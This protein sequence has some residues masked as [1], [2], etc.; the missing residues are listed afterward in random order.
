MENIKRI[1]NKTYVERKI[2]TTE[3]K[4]MNILI[5]VVENEM[6][7]SYIE[8]ENNYYKIVK[9]VNK[10]SKD[11]IDL[12]QEINNI[13]RLEIINHATNNKLTGRLLTLHKRL[14]DFNNLE[15]SYQDNNKTLKIFLT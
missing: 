3:N 6:Y 8:S 2:I 15:F 1:N 5:E 4:T 10:F 11:D 14:G 7:N 13:S 12:K 9:N